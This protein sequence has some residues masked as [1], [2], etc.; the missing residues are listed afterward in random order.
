MTSKPASAE[1]GDMEK[2]LQSE[3][4]SQHL[5]SQPSLK[6][7]TMTTHPLFPDTPANVRGGLTTDKVDIVQTEL[8]LIRDAKLKQLRA[9]KGDST[10]LLREI[11]ALEEAVARL[12]CSK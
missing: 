8:Y 6:L 10:T 2:K 4:H 1:F 7:N 3:V 9:G 12:S 11:Y 5:H